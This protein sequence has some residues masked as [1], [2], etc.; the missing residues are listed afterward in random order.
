MFS[1]A[2]LRERPAEVGLP[3]EVPDPFAGTQDSTAP[4]LSPEAE[5]EM[6]ARLQAL[7]YLE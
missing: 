5:A 3:T 4:A 6:V 1:P 7:G 2:F